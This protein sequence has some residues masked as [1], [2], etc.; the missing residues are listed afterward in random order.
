MGGNLQGSFALRLVSL[1]S[2]FTEFLSSLDGR[3]LNLPIEDLTAVC[4]QH[5]KQKSPKTSPFYFSYAF[6]L[7]FVY[8]R[9]TF[10]KSSI[11]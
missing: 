5:G 7:S 10:V 9:K 2:Q 4:C 1:L 11:K 6:F 8:S 3:K